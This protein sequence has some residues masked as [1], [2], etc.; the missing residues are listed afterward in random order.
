MTALSEQLRRQIAEL[1]PDWNPADVSG[2]IYLEG[3]YS[4]ANYRFEYR[5]DRYV[6]RTPSAPRPFVDRHLEESLYAYGKALGMPE[7]VAFDVATGN[8]IS[9]WVPGVLLADR[10]A[11][12]ADLVDYLRRLH[13]RMPHVARRYD[14]VAQARAHLERAAAPAWVETLAARTRWAPEQLVTCH[15]DLNPW[16]V[17][18]T[19]GGDWIT[20]DWEWAGRNDPLFD[21]V[22]LHQGADI[23]DAELAGMAERYLGEAA[24]P[25]RLDRCLVAFWLR[26][27]AWA[28]AEI[29]AGNDRPEIL[30]Q[31]RLGLARLRA[32]TEGLAS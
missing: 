12:G 24:A 8:L 17:I 29:R 19:P 31:R 9:R 15:N 6:L 26:E 16:N 21:L 13:A 22:T 23:A 28:M 18:V 11:L 4:N 27:A 32:C 25:G 10:R 14:P 7:L 5:G 2:F 1:R 3:G 30:E 20:L